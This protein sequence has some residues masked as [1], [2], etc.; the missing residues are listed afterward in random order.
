MAID[1]H[2]I[3]SAKLNQQAERAG[4]AS[5][6]QR[7]AEQKASR[8]VDHVELSHDAKSTEQLQE[9]IRSSE[10][11]DAERVREITQAISE[12]RYPVNPDRIAQ[13]FLELESQ[14]Y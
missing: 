7:A 2:S 5:R 10:S 4:Q 14:L 13:K 8:D 1:I 3:T 6:E 12:G 11:F 9:R